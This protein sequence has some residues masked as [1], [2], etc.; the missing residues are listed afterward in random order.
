MDNP[1][2]DTC[3]PL[4]I[5]NIEKET[6]GDTSVIAEKPKKYTENLLAVG[7]DHCYTVCG[8]LADGPFTNQ[9]QPSDKTANE[10]ITFETGLPSKELPLLVE[11]EASISVEKERNS[12][13]DV[14]HTIS[15]KTLCS[16]TENSQKLIKWTAP[17]VTIKMYP[18]DSKPHEIMVV[19]KTHMLS[20][21]FKPQ[22]SLLRQSLT[23]ASQ[24]TDHILNN[25]TDHEDK[26]EGSAIAKLLHGKEQVLYSHQ[27]CKFSEKYTSSQIAS[28][29]SF[30]GIDTELKSGFSISHIPRYDRPYSLES[31]KPP[32]NVP[33]QNRFK[34]PFH[35]QQL[36]A[37]T[38][39]P[40]SQYRGSFPSQ[41]GLHV[42]HNFPAQYNYPAFEQ[43]KRTR[44][45]QHTSHVTLRLPNPDFF[46][47]PRFMN[48]RPRKHFPASMEIQNSR[49]YYTYLY[50]QRP[51]FRQSRGRAC[52]FVQ[53]YHTNSSLY[54][55]PSFHGPPLLY[56]GGPTLGYPSD[57]NF[58]LPN[59]HQLQCGLNKTLKMASFQPVSGSEDEADNSLEDIFQPEHGRDEKHNESSDQSTISADLDDILNRSIDEG[60]SAKDCKSPSQKSEGLGDEKIP[61]DIKV[62]HPVPDWEIPLVASQQS[63]PNLKYVQKYEAKAEEK[64]DSLCQSKAGKVKRERNTK[65]KPYKKTS[66]KCPDQDKFAIS[67]NQ[68]RQDRLCMQPKK[69]QKGKKSYSSQQIEA[70]PSEIDSNLVDA[71]KGLLL[72]NWKNYL[73]F[74]M[75]TLQYFEMQNARQHNFNDATI[76]M[77]SDPNLYVWQLVEDINLLSLS[78]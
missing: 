44:F 51:Y 68:G 37:P 9:G 43:T 76:R 54:K 45:A 32:P 23:S 50:K 18:Q 4:P 24:L 42:Q 48:N 75:D 29:R 2:P 72:S 33:Q 41:P 60:T 17:D 53:N 61:S 5:R 21:R 3:D 11:Q 35:C 28:T 63:M 56:T 7:H 73:N 70:V 1:G 13:S 69:G 46:Q 26:C 71:S 55:Y 31:I 38:M 19:P 25:K 62:Q 30:H 57:K 16:N 74:S 27:Q 8:W 66:K 59:A 52:I 65:R 6:D 40:E 20:P 47:H 22:Q 64:M 14:P 36:P 58:N 77:L 34:L 78:L 10:D 49:Y 67:A 12:G 15:I 39:F